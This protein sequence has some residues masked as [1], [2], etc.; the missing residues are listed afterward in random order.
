M[1]GKKH[2]LQKTGT[3]A[4]TLSPNFQYFITSFSSATQPT[5]YTLNDAKDGKQL[6]DTR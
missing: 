4:A 2:C 5:L 6:S 3:N 1:K